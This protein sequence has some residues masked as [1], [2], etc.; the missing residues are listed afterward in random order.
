MVIDTV[1][2]QVDGK[3]ISLVELTESEALILISSLAEQINKRDPNR[4]IFFRTDGGANYGTIFID[5]KGTGKRADKK[6]KS[7]DQ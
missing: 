3:K 1:V 7:N 5:F 6:V 4:R 2:S